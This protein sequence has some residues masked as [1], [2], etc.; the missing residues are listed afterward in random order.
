[1]SVLTSCADLH[2]IRRHRYLGTDIQHQR[3]NVDQD[4]FLG[5]GVDL[6]E[7]GGEG[8]V[9]AAELEQKTDV[10]LGDGLG[11]PETPSERQRDDLD[12]LA[13]KSLNEPERAAIGEP[14]SGG[15]VVDHGG[16]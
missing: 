15:S 10:A 7:P 5:D 16:S 2:V 4:D 8:A 11:D 12:D 9:V 3:P 13:E 14:W 6:P 1:M